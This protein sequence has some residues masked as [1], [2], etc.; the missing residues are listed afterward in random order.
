MNDF[1]MNTLA[2]CQTGKITA[3]QFTFALK[4]RAVHD[5]ELLRFLNKPE[6][7]EILRKLCIEAG[8]DS[9]RAAALARF[10][11]EM[12]SRAIQDELDGIIGRLLIDK[13]MTIHGDGEEK[14]DRRSRLFWKGARYGENR[15]K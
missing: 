6:V 11:I 5:A 2:R 10:D 1:L 4:Q 9:F 15:R 3:E 7:F 13:A 8:N 12:K 14:L